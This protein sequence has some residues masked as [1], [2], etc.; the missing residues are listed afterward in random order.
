MC[1]VVNFKKADFLFLTQIS[2]SVAKVTFCNHK[3]GLESLKS[4][5]SLT[6]LLVKIIVSKHLRFLKHGLFNVKPRI[7]GVS[8]SPDF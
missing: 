2:I 1:F 6:T 4:V 3:K 7:D 5:A 8:N